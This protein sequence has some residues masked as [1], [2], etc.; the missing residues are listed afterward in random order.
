[1][2]VGMLAHVDAGKTTLC[3]AML[4]KSGAIRRLG[5]VDNKDAFLDTDAQERE[6]GITIFSKQA[7]IEYDGVKITL[8]D[9]PGHVDF[10]GEMERALSAMD[11]AVLLISGSDGIEG[12][13]MTLWRLLESYKIPTFI[14]INKMDMPVADK[15]KLLGEIH[16]RLSDSAADMLSDERDERIA[17]C[18]EEALSEYLSGEKISD[19]LISELILTRRLF[20][21]Y[22]G[23]ALRL[24]GVGALLSGICGYMRAKKYQDG[25]SA[26]A[27]KI[28]RDSAGARLTWLKITGGC[29]RVKDALS[30]GGLTEK[31]NQIRQ[32][33]GDKYTLAQEASAGEVCA[34][35]GLSKSRAGE[36]LGL[37][38]GISHMLLEPVFTWRA[39]P[40]DG[41]DS[42]TLIEKLRQLEEEEPSLNVVFSEAVKEIHVQ[43]MG[44]VQLEILSRLML[45]RFG[46]AVAFTGGSILYRETVSEKVTG[47]GHFEP[48]RHY[49][50]VRLTIEPA[51]RGSGITYETAVPED[52]LARSWQRQIISALAEKRHMGVLTG[53]PLSDVKITLTAGR[54]HLK[55][56]EGGDFREAAQRAV[57]QGLM[58]GKSVLLEPWYNISL[59]VPQEAVGRA[60][61]DI[62]EMGGTVEPPEL[63]GQTAL[64]SAAAPVRSARYYARDVSAY[65]RGRGR[66]SCSLRGYAP[67]AEQDRIVAEIGYEPEK[68]GLN[69]A[70]SVF[71][72]NGA[73]YFVKW[74][75]AP[76]FMH[77]KEGGERAPE[78]TGRQPQRAAEKSG[79][80][81]GAEEDMELMRIYERTYGKIKRREAKPQIKQHETESEEKSAQAAAPAAL[82]EKE[83]LKEYLI[84]DGYNII[85]AWDELKKLSEKSLQDAR[86]SL[87]DILANYKGYYPRETILVFDAYKV[88]GNTGSKEEYKG[89]TVVYTK[90]SETADSYIEKTVYD[91]GRKARVYV[92]TS[93]GPEQMMILG[94]GALRVPSSELYGDVKKARIAIADILRRNSLH[95]SGDKA[96]ARAMREAMGRKEK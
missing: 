96:V 43:L 10:S 34:V 46:L 15:E 9:T 6:K 91:I 48:L 89:I 79:L 29:L 53:S 76:D 62:T 37:E 12:H 7:R 78:E 44:E 63:F 26:R 31:V 42:A 21:C 24:E 32:Y 73:G 27:Y 41:C 59:E 65:T 38:S 61:S 2:A 86:Q 69:P 92:A 51:A 25:F 72:A 18:S 55:H 4:Y 64:I 47:V 54:A 80:S 8:M 81:G 70:D 36:G 45:D 74:D 33:S 50:E 39:V 35:T 84:V 85:F 83:P 28:T 19:E 67:C 66:L 90:E 77:I 11:C 22:F 93:D 20:P 56:T 75:K 95:P 3:E 16:L 71:C 57:R 1:M 5:R 13:T 14:F 40:P 23:S 87:M 82:S 17:T 52:E 58:S 60:L 30:A 94:S 49:A 68:D 88:A